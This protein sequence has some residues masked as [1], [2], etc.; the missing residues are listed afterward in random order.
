MYGWAS[1]PTIFRLTSE[2]GHGLL[3]TA[4][5][6]GESSRPCPVHQMASRFVLVVW[7]PIEAMT[8]WPSL[9]NYGRTLFS[10][11][12]AIYVSCGMGIGTA[13][14]RFFRPT[15]LMK[16]GQCPFRPYLEC[17]T[18]RG[19]RRP[20]APTMHP[21]CMARISILVTDWQH[22]RR[23]SVICRGFWLG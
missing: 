2:L 16:R 10:V 1:I 17:S 13:R 3:K 20:I 14:R 6:S 8:C 23:D 11:T 21:A 7:Q 19:A 5:P 18:E 22:G 12:F 4:R 9:K 15:M